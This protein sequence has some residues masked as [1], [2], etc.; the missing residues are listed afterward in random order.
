MIYTDQTA[1][2]QNEGRLMNR[3]ALDLEPVKPETGS[4]EATSG[5]P[6][7]PRRSPWITQYEDV[8]SMNPRVSNSQVVATSKNIADLAYTF[9]KGATSSGPVQSTISESSLISA[10]TQPAVI[11]AIVAALPVVEFSCPE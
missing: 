1:R 2:E 6:V 10:V 9:S 3:F 4:W 5:L 7:L 11:S 8:E